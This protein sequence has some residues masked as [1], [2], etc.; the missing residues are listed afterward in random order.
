LINSWWFEQ[1]YT[2]YRDYFCR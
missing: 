2:V 1:Q